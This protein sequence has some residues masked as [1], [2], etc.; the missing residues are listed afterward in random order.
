MF[1]AIVFQILV[2]DGATINIYTPEQYIRINAAILL[3]CGKQNINYETTDIHR[4]SRYMHWLSLVGSVG[5]LDHNDEST[6]VQL[7]CC[8]GYIGSTY[9]ISNGCVRLSSPLFVG[10]RSNFD[11]SRPLYTQDTSFS[12]KSSLTAV[13]QG[14]QTLSTDIFACERSARN[15][16][17][18]KCDNPYHPRNIVLIY[19]IPG[20]IVI[21]TKYGQ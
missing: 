10:C 8:S 6:A 7:Q 1:E 5:K 19:Y 17:A 18:Q 12:V 2:S 4:G 16:L 21:R 13:C 15:V 3:S 9:D 14:V 11:P 20:Y